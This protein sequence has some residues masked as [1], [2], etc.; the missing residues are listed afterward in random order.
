MSAMGGKTII[1]SVPRV[2]EPAPKLPMTD[3]VRRTLVIIEK[4]KNM[5]TVLSHGLS[6]ITD[7]PEGLKPVSS[8][9]AALALI[10][11]HRPDIVI[12][13]EGFDHRNRTAPHSV[14][15]RARELN[16]RAKVVL[17]ATSLAHDGM[18]GYDAVID[19]L[20]PDRVQRFVEGL[21]GQ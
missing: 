14:L 20:Y 21:A 17:Y 4:N 1:A 3:T 5:L 10:D 18:N 8:L 15:G 11:E 13:D 2:R 9:A 6:K 19:R 12:C 16:P 7:I